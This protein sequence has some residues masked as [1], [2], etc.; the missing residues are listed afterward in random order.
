M[1]HFHGGL[2]DHQSGADVFD[3]FQRRQAVGLERAAGGYQ[4]HDFM[5][6][7]DD[8][9]AALD[10]LSAFGIDRVQLTELAPGSHSRL[11]ETL[12]G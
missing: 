8:V 11:A 4:V 2:V 7:A 10:K 3:V 5:G 1:F 9:A 6:H 12:L